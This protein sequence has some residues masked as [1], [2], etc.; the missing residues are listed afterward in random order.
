VEAAVNSHSTKGGPA[1]EE[2]KR[3]INKEREFLTDK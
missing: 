1:F 2:S 3:V